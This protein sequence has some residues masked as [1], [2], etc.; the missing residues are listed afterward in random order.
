M[1]TKPFNLTICTLGAALVAAFLALTT[2][3]AHA[4]LL[5][6]FSA[7]SEPMDWNGP[8]I[9]FDAAGGVWSHIGISNYRTN[10]DLT[11]QFNVATGTTTPEGNFIPNNATTPN[12]TFFSAPGHSSDDG[13]YLAGIDLGYNKQFGHFVVGG[14]FGFTGTKVTDESSFRDFQE[15][16]I[17]VNPGTP[18]VPQD[19]IADTDFHSWRHVEQLWA[20]YVGGQLGFA[21]NRFLIYGLG[22]AAFAQI[23][24]LSLDR[25]FTVFSQNVIPV[26]GQ[27][28][29]VVL[30]Q[31]VDK[32]RLQNNTIQ[33]GWFAGGGLQYAF[34]DTWSA[35]LEYRHNSYGDTEYHLNVGD[36]GHAGVFPG[37]TTVGVENNQVL[38]KVTVW[39][40]HLGEKHAAAPGLSKK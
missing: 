27:Q 32:P 23:D 29:N 36:K 8:F 24:V 28:G 35:G 1:Q 19:V 5:A 37:A 22:G 25:A 26:A 2:P 34:N 7:P 15:N 6:I 30:G 40:G 18:P 3:T 38:F 33:A 11:R 17:S 21:W 39:L 16:I 13:A 12:V 9:S 10:V 4:G 14:V 31:T 20:G